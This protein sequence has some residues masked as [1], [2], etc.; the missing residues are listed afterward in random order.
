MASSRAEF[1]NTMGQI[2]TKPEHFYVTKALNCNSF[3][4]SRAGWIDGV[5]ECP[6]GLAGN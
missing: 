3:R 5:L 1:F 6:V 4:S 2:S